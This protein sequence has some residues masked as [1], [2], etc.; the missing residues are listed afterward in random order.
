MEP[1]ETWILQNP[2]WV[3]APIRIWIVV[4]MLVIVV[5]RLR[6]GSFHGRKLASRYGV[7]LITT[8]IAVF[9]WLIYGKSVL[10]WPGL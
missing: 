1:V 6:R 8:G 9:A 4:W 3:D 7:L 10:G 5:H 2:I